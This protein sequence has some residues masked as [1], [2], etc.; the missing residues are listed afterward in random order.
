[1][2][3]TD[4]ARLQEPRRPK[5]L[6]NKWCQG[7]RRKDRLTHCDG[8]DN[9]V[10]SSAYSNE[11]SKHWVPQRPMAQTIWGKCKTRLKRAPLTE[12]VAEALEDVIAGADFEFH[13]VP[14]CPWMCAAVRRRLLAVAPVLLLA[15][16]KS[17]AGC[18]RLSRRPLHRSGGSIFAHAAAVSVQRQGRF[19]QGHA[20]LLFSFAG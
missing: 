10:S 15:R 5:C 13:D 1:M 11:T 12:A 3:A 9:F 8:A 20:P 4:P 17:P 2:A 19:Y 6:E 18:P 7:R 16:R 14:P